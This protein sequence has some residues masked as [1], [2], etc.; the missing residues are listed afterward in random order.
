VKEIL[1]IIIVIIIVIIIIIIIKMIMIDDDDNNNDKTFL[2]LILIIMITM[3][4]QEATPVTSQS[5][6]R[7]SS[8]RKRYT[9][10]LTYACTCIHIDYNLRNACILLH[11][12]IGEV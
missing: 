7:A 4:F 10:I 12:K 1:D 6:M 11:R 5:T 3:L 9:N 8:K 2:I